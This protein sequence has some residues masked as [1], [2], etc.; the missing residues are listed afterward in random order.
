VTCAE[1]LC[2]KLALHRSARLDYATMTICLGLLGCGEHSEIGH[3]IPLARY[4]ADHAGAI[5]LLAA[6]DLRRERAEVFCEKYRF[7]RAYHDLK[8]MLANEQLDVCIAVVPVEHIADIG[9]RLLQAN[10]PCVVEKPLG[11]TIGEV[12]R[13]RD[14][15]RATNTINMVSVNR[16]FMPLLN[17]GAEWSRNAGPL[18]Y[19]R[20]TMIRH[21]RTEPDFL[22]STAI[23][24][25]DTL[26]FIAGDFS[27]GDI[28]TL[29]TK[30][31]YWY[32]ID[33]QFES[34][35]RGRIDILPTAGLLEETYELMGDGFRSVITSPFGSQRALRCYRENRL[36]LEEI[37]GSDTPEDV[38]NGFYGEVTELVEALSR[39]Q[40]PKPSI[41]E[42]FRSVELCFGLADRV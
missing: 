7:A 32:A 42:V 40:R 1:H 36:V 5:S 13:L 39:K 19:V 28:R 25:F 16:R 4:A 11:T 30:P 37:P 27:S 20:C 34:G 17:R 10:V 24:A 2:S 15:A 41:E 23:H 29:N 26:R 12:T 6:C 9:I 38:I 21:A 31:P 35:A 18:R 14:V 22:R 8:E 33:L 3:A